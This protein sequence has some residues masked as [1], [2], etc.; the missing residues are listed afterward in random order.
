MLKCRLCVENSL[1][2]DLVK[3]KVV[4][5]DGPFGAKQ[6]GFASGAAGIVMH[7]EAD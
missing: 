3:G 1:D 4:L 6:F 5:C 7:S 2:Q